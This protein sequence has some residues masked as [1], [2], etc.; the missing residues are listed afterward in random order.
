M[1]RL[2]K[3]SDA[4]FPACLS[5]RHCSIDEPVTYRRLMI[6]DLY[7]ATPRGTS[8]F[9]SLRIIQAY[10]YLSSDLSNSTKAHLPLHPHG[11][12]SSTR[13]Y[14]DTPQFEGS[15]CV[16]LH[17]DNYSNRVRPPQSSPT[18][19]SVIHICPFRQN[20]VS[21]HIRYEHCASIQLLPTQ[22]PRPLSSHE[23][24]C[25]YNDSYLINLIMSTN[26]R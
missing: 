6:I 2:E 5:T 9:N 3:S 10:N 14:L 7:L 22:Q 16:Y 15:P 12:S 18:Y 20:V 17:R 25:S 24:F 19:Y 13:P 1:R 8:A 4:I 21:Q 23:V 11:Y 26:V